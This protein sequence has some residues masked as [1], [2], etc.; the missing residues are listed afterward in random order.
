MAGT[1]TPAAT[2]NGNPPPT[3]A[4][5]SMKVGPS[6]VKIHWIVIGPCPGKAPAIFSQASRIGPWSIVTDFIASPPRTA[7]RR[8]ETTCTSCPSKS[9][10]TSDVISEPSTNSWM[11][12]SGT[13]GRARSN[14]PRPLTRTTPS[15]ALPL[16]GFTTHGYLGSVLLQVRRQPRRSGADR[17]LTKKL[18]RLPFVTGNRRPQW[19]RYQTLA[20][21]S[22]QTL[23]EPRPARGSRDRSAE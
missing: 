17:Q 5:I 2:A 21:R 7:N 10:I 3:R 16:R 6:S 8:R 22:P 13:R 9:Q 18:V 1:S 14:S 11:I 19:F 4:L 15:P 12:G 20:Y 23:P